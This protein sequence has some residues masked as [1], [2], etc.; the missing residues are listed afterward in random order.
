MRRHYSHRSAKKKKISLRDCDF[1]ISSCQFLILATFFWNTGTSV[2]SARIYKINI[3]ISHLHRPQLL[4]PCHRPRE[5]NRINSFLSY[6]FSKFKT[7]PVRIVLC[8][9]WHQKISRTFFQVDVTSYQQ[10]KQRQRNKRWS[11]NKHDLKK[12]STFCLSFLFIAVCV[13]VC[14]SLPLSLF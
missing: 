12:N 14:L 9:S 1:K 2:G 4:L 5:I 11:E 13:F 3:R 8:W 6:L 10:E 7:S